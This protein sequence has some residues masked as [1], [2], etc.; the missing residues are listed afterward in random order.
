MLEAISPLGDFDETINSVR[1][2]EIAGFG[3]IALAVPM[4]GEKAFATALKKETGCA[5]P[6]P[7]HFTS[8]SGK[9]V[10][11]IWTQRD[12]VFLFNGDETPMQEISL[13]EKFA[14][15]AYVTDQSDGW[16]VLEVSGERALEAL[17]RICPINLNPAVFYEGMAARTVM[18]HL[19]VLIL[20]T[21]SDKW[22][23]LSARSSALSF[24]HA[25]TQSAK[26][27]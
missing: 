26:N 16:A 24:L 12:Q 9:G 5:L 18:E 3:L 10:L 20:R 13:R 25:V 7:G 2:R 4:G 11:L 27:L 17:E 1:I 6:E 22:L 15:R 14:T 8:N 21:A 23:L 19:G